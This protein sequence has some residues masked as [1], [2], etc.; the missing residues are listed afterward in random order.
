[1]IFQEIKEL[2]EEGIQLLKNVP[3]DAPLPIIQIIKQATISLLKGLKI[4]INLQVM[5][6]LNKVSK[7]NLFLIKPF[8]LMTW[9]LFLNK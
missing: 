5:N 7:T 4:N 1:M 9:G 8:K 2:S 3:S 6:F